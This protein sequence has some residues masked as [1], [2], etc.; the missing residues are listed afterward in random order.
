V[1]RRGGRVALAVWGPRA[2]CGW[3]PVLEIV[4]A[5][6]TGDV[7]PLFF[8]LGSA[9]ALAGA[10]REAGFTNVESRRLETTLAYVDVAEACAAAFVGGPV[11]LAW[12]RF[13]A[14]VRERVRNRYLEAL[15]RWRDGCGLPR[16]CVLCHRRR[17]AQ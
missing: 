9:D 1:L 14:G 16:A 3:A 6:V 4:D 8:R 12:S 2:S 17:Q 13:D 7:C 5:E 11:A 15:A 10:C